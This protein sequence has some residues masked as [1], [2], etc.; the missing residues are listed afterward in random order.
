[1]MIILIKKKQKKIPETAVLR[2]TLPWVLA[3][4]YQCW[5]NDAFVGQQR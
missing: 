5:L 2:E 1:M 3:E 4:L